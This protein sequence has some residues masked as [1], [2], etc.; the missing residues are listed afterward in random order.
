[1]V[2]QSGTEERE[3]IAAAYREAQELVATIPEDNGDARPRIE[4]CFARSDIYRAM[5][6]LA[7]VGWILT[8]LQERLKERNLPGSRK[9]LEI[10]TESLKL[11]RPLNPT[12]H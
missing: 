3:R 10:I 11:L 12:I 5:D 7:C 4:A 6:D 8:A 9:L 1:M 2:L